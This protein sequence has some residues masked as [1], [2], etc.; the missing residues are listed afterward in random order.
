[1]LAEPAEK[2]LLG[3]RFARHSCV[4]YILLWQAAFPELQLQEVMPNSPLPP[5]VPEFQESPVAVLGETCF[6]SFKNF[7]N[8]STS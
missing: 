4:N 8:S 3:W 6:Y 5:L 2:A 1:M 7:L